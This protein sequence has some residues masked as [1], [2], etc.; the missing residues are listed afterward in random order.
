MMKQMEAVIFDWAGTTVDYGCMAP[1]YAMQKAFSEYQLLITLDEIRQPMG[2]LKKDHIKAVLEMSRVKKHFHD[3][4]HKYPETVD[5]E[6]LYADFEKNIF[7]NLDQ[8]TQLIDGILE[9]QTYLRKHHIKMGSTTGYTRAMID[10]VAES[11]KKQ[12]YQPDYIISSDQ[13]K[14]GRPYPYMLHQNLMALDVR[15]L[16]Q[17]VKVG[18]TIVDIQE[19]LYAGCWSVGV[20]KGSSMLGLNASEAASMPDAELSERVQVVKYEMLA[21]GAHFVIDTIGE[22]P[23]LIDLIHHRMNSG[24]NIKMESSCVV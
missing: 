21:A 6:K 2:M 12:G 14:K 10:I 8:H 3:V 23:S 17:V 1:I 20:V 4:Y 16:R 19:G 22:L 5:I 7:L 15:D 9:V 18:D 13:V 11:A 24:E